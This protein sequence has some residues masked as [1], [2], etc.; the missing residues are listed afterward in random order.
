MTTD[1]DAAW[2][3]DASYATG[4]VSL[5]FIKAGDLEP[6]HRIDQFQPYYLT[7]DEQQGEPVRKLNL[8]TQNELTLYKVNYDKRPPKD[9]RAWESEIDP[10]LSYIYDKRLRFGV[11]HRLEG[12]A[13]LPQVS[14]DAEQS[15][16]FDSFSVKS[17]RRTLSSIVW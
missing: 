12:N 8:F 4:Q 1:G 10:A 14:L 9:I 3:V 16:R 11:L 15:S 5:R 7:E 2:L 6:I 17:K 13:W